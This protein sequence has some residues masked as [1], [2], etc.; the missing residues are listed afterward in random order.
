MLD[1]RHYHTSSISE[2]H[3][4]TCTYVDLVHQRPQLLVPNYE[5]VVVGTGHELNMRGSNEKMVG[6]TYVNSV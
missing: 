1:F 6:C 3:P 2:E 4:V 5:Y